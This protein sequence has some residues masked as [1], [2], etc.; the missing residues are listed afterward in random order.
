MPAVHSYKD[1]VVSR[2]YKGLQGLVKA[3]KVTY[4]E[5]EGKLVSPT[6]VEV[7]GKRYEGRHVLLATG[8]APKSL[9]G[10]DI[11]RVRVITSEQALT[12]DR[13]PASMVVLGG[14]VI[15]VE[16]A[17]VWKSFGAEVTI[18]EALPHLLPLEDEASSKLLERAFRRRGINFELGARFE[19]A[20]TTDAGV[21]V[22]LEG[23]K[24][25][26]AE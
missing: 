2:L 9:P 19:S 3:H 10:L 21:V 6:V 25:I 23:G 20:K 26:D 22:T 8:S 18:V 7:A 14:G 15:G 24:T 4:V 16:F 1:G 5:G 17:S 11:D 12:L 13:V